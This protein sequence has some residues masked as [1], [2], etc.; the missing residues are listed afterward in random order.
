MIRLGICGVFLVY[1]A[2]CTM[3]GF[4]SP[5]DLASFRSDLPPS[6]R[7]FANGPASVVEATAPPSGRRPG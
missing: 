6:R 5:G 7:S 3:A 4:G 1:A 2:V